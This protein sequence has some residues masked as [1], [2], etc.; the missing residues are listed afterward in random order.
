MYHYWRCRDTKIMYPFPPPPPT[1]CPPSPPPERLQDPLE[2][3]WTPPGDQNDHQNQKTMRKRP[4][5]T[6]IFFFLKNFTCSMPY[7]HCFL[8]LFAHSATCVNRLVRRRGDL[9]KT[10]KNLYVLY[11]FGI[12]TLARA[13]EQNIGKLLQNNMET[14]LKNQCALET[15]F[16]S[17]GLLWGAF[18]VRF[19]TQMA[20]R[21]TQRPPK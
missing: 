2:A 13:I 20:P 10:C 8:I 11:K 14:H 7:L 1:K 21:R 18:W 16:Y 17:F 5:T 9:R 3:I 19:G 4:K 15:F 12:P 6:L